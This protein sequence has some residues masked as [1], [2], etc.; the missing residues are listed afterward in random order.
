[1]LKLSFKTAEE[2]VEILNEAEVF[3]RERGLRVK[4]KGS[5]TLNLE[6]GGG[7]VRV[8]IFDNGASEVT[9]ET[10]EWESSVKEFATRHK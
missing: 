7:Y 2:P 8:D 3:F 6:G 4:E 5:C 1:L 10:R 9:I